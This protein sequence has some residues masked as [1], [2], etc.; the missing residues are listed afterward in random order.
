[1]AGTRRMNFISA[2]MVLINIS[3]HIRRGRRKLISK[4]TKRLCLHFEVLQA[5]DTFRSF[6]FIFFHKNLSNVLENYITKI[7]VLRWIPIWVR[8][9]IRP[10]ITR[11]WTGGAQFWS[12]NLLLFLSPISRFSFIKAETVSFLNSYSSLLEPQ[13]PIKDWSMTIE[14]TNLLHSTRTQELQCAS[15]CIYLRFSPP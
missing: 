7:R 6:F 12:R 13:N 1:M 3:S 10:Q 9:Q 8:A 5:H 4:L 2:F 15:D 14:I 11:T